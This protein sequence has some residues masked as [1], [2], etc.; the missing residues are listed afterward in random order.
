MRTFAIGDVHGMLDLLQQALDFIESY[1]GEKKVVF[2]G[3]YVDRGPCSCG[4]IDKLSAY[5]SFHPDWVFLRGNH[6]HMFMDEA[7]EWDHWLPHYGWHTLGSYGGYPDV[8]ED[9]AKAAL[10]RRHQRWVMGLPTVHEDEHRIY[11]HAGL[12]PGRTPEETRPSDRMWIR[13]EFLNSDYDWGKQVIHGHTVCLHDMS[14]KLSDPV[15]RPNR[16]NLDTGACFPKDGGKLTVMFWDGPDYVG[17]EQFA[18]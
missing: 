13:E 11:V 1:E 17:Y 5:Q 6:D 4:V 9:S 10:L 12:R 15:I 8:F 16:I 2:L 7:S 18:R 3:D 14:S